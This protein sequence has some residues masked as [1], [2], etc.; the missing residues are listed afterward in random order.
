MIKSRDLTN[1]SQRSCARCVHLRYSSPYYC[2][3]IDG[4]IMPDKDLMTISVCGCY[5]EVKKSW[6]A[7]TSSKNREKA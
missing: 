4:E 5:K 3:G 6:Q 2:C 7:M 1:D